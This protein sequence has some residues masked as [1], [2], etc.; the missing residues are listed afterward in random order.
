MVAA[1]LKD[2]VPALLNIKQ[3]RL[4]ETRLDRVADP[5]YGLD[6][7]SA[8]K[9]FWEGLEPQFTS[10]KGRY[11]F[12]Y[13]PCLKCGAVLDVVFPKKGEPY[14]YCDEKRK[15]WENDGSAPGLPPVVPGCGTAYSL[16]VGKDG[17]PV[18]FEPFE[19][20]D[21]EPCKNC[22][23]TEYKVRASRT[24]LYSNCKNCSDRQRYVR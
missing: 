19:V 23:G 18:R 3:T 1:F 15:P 22:G 20:E 11:L 2:A 21:G 8:L 4:T 10:A 6:R 12:C 9:L 13:D 7:V 16:W 14:L 17:G 24:G 5:D